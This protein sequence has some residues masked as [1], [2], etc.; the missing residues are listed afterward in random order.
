MKHHLDTIN[1]L[2]Q[3]FRESQ[4]SY[5]TCLRKL[6]DS[7][8]LDVNSV[9]L[10]ESCEQGDDS[11][12]GVFVT[13]DRRVFQFAALSEKSCL[14]VKSFSEWKDISSEWESSPY[15]EVVSIGLG[16]ISM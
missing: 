1:K 6:V 5:W 11:E 2:I 7:K 12:F 10:V 3:L 4:D 13:K 14:G 16:K 15:R 9:V 8:G